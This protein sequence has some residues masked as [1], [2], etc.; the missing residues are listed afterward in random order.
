[1]TPAD[2]ARCGFD[3]TAHDPLDRAIITGLHPWAEICSAYTRP[4]PRWRVLLARLV[5][6][7]NTFPDNLRGSK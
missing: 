4:V 3:P 1:M 5:L 2:C 7:I 6:A